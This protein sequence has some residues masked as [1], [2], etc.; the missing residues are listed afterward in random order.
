MDEKL[1]LPQPK[2]ISYN[3]LAD[4]RMSKVPEV[5]LAILDVPAPSSCTGLNVQVRNHGGSEPT[6][7]DIYVFADVEFVVPLIERERFLRRIQLS[8]PSPLSEHKESSGYATY[9]T[10]THE[11][12]DSFLVTVDVRL[13]LGDRPEISVLDAL[14]PLVAALRSMSDT[15]P[16]AFICHASEDKSTA[17][18]IAFALRDMGAIVWLDEWEI[19]VGESIVERVNTRIE[20]CS[21]LVLLLSSHSV[22]KP[23]VQ[24]EFSAALMRQLSERQVTVLPVRLDEA[25]PPKII[26]DIKYADAR[27]SVVD[28]IDQLRQVLF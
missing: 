24:R 12:G 11:W 4:L 28:A 21:H 7:T 13:D 19:K 17:R 23:W 14:S 1:T 16:K 27:T 26:G 18:T 6:R 20:A 8:F 15:A 25:E 3:H 5:G 10:F 22:S 9:R 2:E